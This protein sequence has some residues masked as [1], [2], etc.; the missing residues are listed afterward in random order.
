MRIVGIMLSLLGGQGPVLLVASLCLGVIFLP[1]GDFGYRLLPL[2]A[3]LLTL[4]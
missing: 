4:G 2:S 1:L 3:F